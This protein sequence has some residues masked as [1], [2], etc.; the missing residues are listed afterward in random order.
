MCVR[1]LGRIG[2]DWEGFGG[3]PRCPGR[4]LKL[5]LMCPWGTEYNVKR[6]CCLHYRPRKRSNE[7][8]EFAKPSV[9]KSAA[10]KVQ[11]N[12]KSVFRAWRHTRHAPHRSDTI[13]LCRQNDVDVKMGEGEAMVGCL[14]LSLVAAYEYLVPLFAC[15]RGGTARLPPLL[16]GS[17]A[18]GIHPDHH[19]GGPTP[20]RPP[21][22]Y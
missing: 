8:C 4:N 22:V 12:V 13:R 14:P 10:A 1:L 5:V 20:S 9:G 3:M 18:D 17:D 2:R 11:T 16:D 19:D 15:W 7:D 6:P 21:G